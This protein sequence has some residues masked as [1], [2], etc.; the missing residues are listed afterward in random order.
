M[1]SARCFHM[2]FAKIQG[3]AARKGPFNR[4]FKP[5]Y[6]RED[7]FLSGYDLVDIV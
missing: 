1:H 5:G 6:V 7:E 4:L 2:F 3:Y